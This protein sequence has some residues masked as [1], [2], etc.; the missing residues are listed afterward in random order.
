LNW[1]GAY[2]TSNKAIGK[3]YAGFIVLAVDNRRRLIFGF[4]CRK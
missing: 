3:D 2:E 1:G 4:Q